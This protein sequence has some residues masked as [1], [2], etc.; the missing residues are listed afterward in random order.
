MEQTQGYVEV[1]N[2][3]IKRILEKLV[4]PSRKDWSLKLDDALWAHRTCYKTPIG[5]TLFQL[6]YGK[7][8]HLT[9][10][11]QCRSSWA[12]QAL[13]LDPIVSQEKRAAQLRELEELRLDAFHNK[14]IYKEQTIGM[15]N[16]SSSE[17]Y[18]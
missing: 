15:T 12:I 4:N 14:H 11:L 18:L 1:A 5:T 9:M 3:K 2:K 17:S 7:S 6:L 13:N 16:G 8:F 10:V